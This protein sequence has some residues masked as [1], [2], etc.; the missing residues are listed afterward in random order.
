MSGAAAVTTTQQQDVQQV[1][2]TEP[3]L[4]ASPEGWSEILEKADTGAKTLDHWQNFVKQSYKDVQTTWMPF[5]IMFFV[6]NIIV[7]GSACCFIYAPL[8][9]STIAF[10][11]VL[12]IIIAW[13]AYA[14]FLLSGAETMEYWDTLAGRSKA[15]LVGIPCFTAFLSLVS[16]YGKGNDAMN[17]FFQI[18]RALREV[19]MFLYLS[20]AFPL[21]MES[22]FPGAKESFL[23]CAGEC[24]SSFNVRMPSNPFSKSEDEEYMEDT[25]EEEK[26]A[27]MVPTSPEEE[28]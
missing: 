13:D 15:L 26:D 19:Y 14:V 17:V 27:V 18:S 24:I 5:A 9:G 2:E 20:W 8:S 3:L 28:I 7:F 21:Y 6:M 22:Q 23:E 1:S 12:T 25:Q 11:V 10:D 16:S 4:S